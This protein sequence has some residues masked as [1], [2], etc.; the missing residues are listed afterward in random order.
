MMGLRHTDGINKAFTEDAILQQIFGM[1]PF[2]QRCTHIRT[3]TEASPVS[4]VFTRGGRRQPI[5]APFIR[6]IAHMCHQAG[7]RAA[8][9]AEGATARLQ[10]VGKRPSEALSSMGMC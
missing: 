10:A 8:L 4:A 6:V 5:F 3:V 7:E 2:R 1:L 9:Q